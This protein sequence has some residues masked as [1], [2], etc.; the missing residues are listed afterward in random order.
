M[1]NIT[2][3]IP[4]DKVQLVLDSVSHVH[5]Y[6]QN[7]LEGE[8]QVQFAKRLL[9]KWL[10][11]SVRHYREFQEQDAFYQNLDDE[12]EQITID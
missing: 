4:D 10:K 12:V 2:I 6:D 11:S 8:T 7:K 5:G 1:A 3:T 9:I